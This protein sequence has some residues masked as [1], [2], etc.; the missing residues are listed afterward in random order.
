MTITVIKSKS[1]QIFGG[2]ADRSWDNNN[3]FIHGERKSFIFSLTKNTKHNC[4]NKKNELYA[5]S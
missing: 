4:L 1:G 2:F 3:W 5:D